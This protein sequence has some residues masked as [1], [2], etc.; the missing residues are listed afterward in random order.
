MPERQLEAVVLGRIVR[1]GD[2][3]AADDVEV[4]QRSSRAA[5]SARRRCRRRRRPAPSAR[6]RAR[7]AAP[8]PLGRLSRPTATAPATPCSR[9]GTPRTR[10]P[11]ASRGLDGQIALDDAADVV[12]AKDSGCDV[13]FDAR[14]GTGPQRGPVVISGLARRCVAAS[15]R[16]NRGAAA[17]AAIVS[18][19]RS[20]SRH[21]R[22]ARR[23]RRSPAARRA[24]GS[25]TTL[26]AS[27]IRVRPRRLRAA[28]ARSPGAAS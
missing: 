1:A 6:R 13:P 24:R 21:V 27:T 15:C 17:V 20:A 10:A 2:L 22:C 26:V 16:A 25:A 12:L 9:A 19:W 5:A 23:A 7:R 3:D 8:A 18:D 4:V 11:I 14:N 28:L